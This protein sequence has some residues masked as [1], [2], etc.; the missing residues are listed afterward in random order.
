[1]K[2]LILALSLIGIAFTSQATEEKIN[3]SG[4][5]LSLV[6]SGNSYVA[7]RDNF[8]C[9]NCL[10][11]K[12]G[13]VLKKS[14]EPDALSM[15]FIDPRTP[16][17]GWT[18]DVAKKGKY[19]LSG[20]RTLLAGIEFDCKARYRIVTISAYDGYF[21]EGELL[22]NEDKATEWNLIYPG[23]TM[24]FLKGLSCRNKQ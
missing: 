4:H 18:M 11:I 3:I 5:E 9:T 16:G 19:V 10:V 23:S 21:R 24:E 7:V 15:I 22:L 17:I 8:A 6:K 2:K 14:A 1:M 13:K 20:A 12:D